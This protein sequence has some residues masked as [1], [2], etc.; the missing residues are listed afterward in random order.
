MP[1]CTPLAVKGLAVALAGLAG[2]TVG[3]LGEM[4]KA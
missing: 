2:G 1:L 3:S 4:L